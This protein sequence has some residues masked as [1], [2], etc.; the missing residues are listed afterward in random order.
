M[1][2]QH[3]RFARHVIIAEDDEIASGVVQTHCA[4]RPLVVGGQVMHCG[5]AGDAKAALI[6]ES[7]RAIRRNIPDL[8]GTYRADR[9]RQV[10]ILI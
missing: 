10:M 4:D 1:R 2:L 8:S 9:T 7:A 5:H 3:A 6:I